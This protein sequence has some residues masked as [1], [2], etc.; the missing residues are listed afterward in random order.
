MR[1]GT[2]VSKYKVRRYKVSYNL[3]TPKPDPKIEK[4]LR[5]EPIKVTLLDVYTL[6]APYVGVRIKDQLKAVVPLALYLGLFQV[7]VLD[8]PIQ[9]A[10]ALCMGL[11]AV[12]IG[13][14]VFMEGLNSGLMPFG[15]IIGTNLPTKATMPVVLVVLGMLG[16]GVTFAEPAIGS[17]EAS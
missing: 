4:S 15:N 3:L 16:V 6:L 12:I 9:E 8:Y 1:Y 5:P 2:F 10:A 14:A 7:F 11:V 13:L 17:L